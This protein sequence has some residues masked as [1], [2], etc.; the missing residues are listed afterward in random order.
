M[1]VKSILDSLTLPK[2]C[3]L[4]ALPLLVAFGFLFQQMYTQ[5]N[6][7]I[8]SSENELQGAVAL[9]KITPVFQNILA[10]R[11]QKQSESASRAIETLNKLK[12]EL[13]EHWPNTKANIGKIVELLPVALSK[14]ATPAQS[15][16]LGNHMVTLVRQ[17]ADESEL[18]LDPYLPS[19]YMMS[20]MA[21]QLP[22]VM[23]YLSDLEGKLRFQGSDTA[24]TLSFARSRIGTLNRALEEI[25]EATENRQLLA[26]TCLPMYANTLTPSTADWNPSRAG[27]KPSP[28]RT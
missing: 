8:G 27:Y 7:L 25:R 28:P 6:T 10:D 3:A 19:Y 9:E 15:D 24:G 1:P 16:A 21:F 2:K 20:P 11:A 26:Q 22:G 14:Q 13:P 12:A 23:E 17:L 4:I 5:I 18:T